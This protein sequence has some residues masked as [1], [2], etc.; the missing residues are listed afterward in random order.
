[1]INEGIL[2][3]EE[4]MNFGI[5]YGKITRVDINEIKLLF[6]EKEGRKIFQ[7]SIDSLKQTLLDTFRLP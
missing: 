1:M 2:S 5:N 6:D 4:L 3:I 7:K